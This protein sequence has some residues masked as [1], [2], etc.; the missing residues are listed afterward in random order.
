MASC[1]S[2]LPPM[3]YMFATGQE[4]VNYVPRLTA[5]LCVPEGRDAESGLLPSCHYR[6][7]IHKN[8]HPQRNQ[9]F[10][11]CPFSHLFH[12]NFLKGFFIFSQP[13]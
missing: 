5:P 7:C 8:G 2:T 11:L 4:A 3:T 10:A 6:T 9:L 12:P 13:L 1:E